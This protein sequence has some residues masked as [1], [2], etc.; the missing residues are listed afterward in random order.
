MKIL[1]FPNL[2]L[3]Q[4]SLV[5]EGR[6][7]YR[8]AIPANSNRAQEGADA[9]DEQKKIE[10][11]QKKIEDLQAEIKAVRGKVADVGV[12]RSSDEIA[13][14][15]VA[16]KGPDY[17]KLPELRPELH[18]I[19]DATRLAALATFP[20][21]AVTA[22]AGS[23]IG[24]KVAGK[25]TGKKWTAKDGLEKVVPMP[26]RLTNSIWGGATFLPKLAGASGINTL[27]WMNH[28]IGKPVIGTPFNAI[29]GK[30]GAEKERPGLI[31][32]SIN[33]ARDTVR[34]TIEIFPSVPKAIGNTVSS[35][36]EAF[37]NHPVATV[38]ASGGSIF[39]ATDLIANG[40]VGTIAAAKGIGGILNWFVK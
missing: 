31:R 25:I 36:H 34:N 33:A 3:E 23:A 28:R 35:I 26:K 20:A 2:A 19:M 29:F 8:M 5:S 27:K 10:E 39:L 24:H 21:L 32:T 40:G 38:A 11:Q 16:K 17:M 13:N 18:H 6:F 15:P 30:E 4:S 9:S 12:Q 7:I 37:K 14:K 22:A 1:T